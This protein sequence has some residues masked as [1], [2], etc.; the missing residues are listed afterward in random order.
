ML[1]LVAG[2]L[3]LALT[4][5]AWADQPSYSFAGAAYQRVELDD[6]GLNIDGNG[7]SIGG[8]FEIGDNWHVFGSYSS[9]DFGFGI[10]VNTLQVG[11]GYHV[12]ISDN[13]SFFTNLSLVRAEVDVGIL[14]S[15]DD[16]GYGLTIGMRSNVSE[17]FEAEGSLSYV[18]LGNGAD[19]LAAGGAGWYRLSDSFAIGLIVYF[20][21][22]VV[23]YGIGGRYYFGN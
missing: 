9:T 17:R 4:A 21:E 6:L 13:T 2:A 10:D 14:G 3:V 8:S 16:D 1:R 5:P 20:D 23:A 22:D 7:L 11:A 12:L 15:V 19:G 18:D